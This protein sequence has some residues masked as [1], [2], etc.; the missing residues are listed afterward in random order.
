[1]E[2]HGRQNKPQRACY[3]KDPFL[4]EGCEILKPRVKDRKIDEKCVEG[5]KNISRDFEV[6]LC[7]SA[8]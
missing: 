6:E 3:E 2:C 1:M 5:C 7:S 4:L 8:L